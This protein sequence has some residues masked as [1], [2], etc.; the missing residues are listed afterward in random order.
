[1][2]MKIARLDADPG[3]GAASASLSLEEALLLDS[4]TEGQVTKATAEWRTADV[5][6]IDALLHWADNDDAA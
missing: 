4:M 2:T 1:M 5:L 3:P 6:A